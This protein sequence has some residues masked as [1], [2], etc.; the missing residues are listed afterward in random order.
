MRFYQG[1]SVE[2][3]RSECFGNFRPFEFA[4]CFRRGYAKVNRSLRCDEEVVA[5]EAVVLA[6]VLGAMSGLSFAVYKFDQTQHNFPVKL[7]W[8]DEKVRQKLEDLGVE[9]SLRNSPYIIVS[10][11]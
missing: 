10:P 3:S 1:G 2:D 6:S 7:V 5:V 9:M 11:V 4:E 8:I